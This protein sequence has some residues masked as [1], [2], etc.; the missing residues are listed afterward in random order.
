[1]NKK[2]LNAVLTENTKPQYH[3]HAE[4]IACNS[5]N[6]TQ[7]YGIQPPKKNNV[8]IAPIINILPYSAIKIAANNTEA[9]STLLPATNSAS[10]SIKSKGARFVSAKDVMTNNNQTGKRGQ[11]YQIF[12]W[13]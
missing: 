8:D 3:E 5:S 10:A 7:E 11:I 1:M 2:T 4:S 13:L 9:Y 6:D 12:I